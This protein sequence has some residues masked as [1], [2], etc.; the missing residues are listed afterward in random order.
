MKN[1]IGNIKI[2][3]SNIKY[4]NSSK[5][6]KRKNKAHHFT[7]ART[8]IYSQKDIFHKKNIEKNFDEEINIVK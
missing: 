7:L 4:N 8:N 3:T 5:I 6:N 1:K 2:K